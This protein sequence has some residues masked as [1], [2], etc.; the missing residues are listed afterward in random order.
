[1]ALEVRGLVAVELDEMGC[2]VILPQQ[3]YALSLHIHITGLVLRP[4]TDLL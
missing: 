2:P 4:R 1:M 3:V